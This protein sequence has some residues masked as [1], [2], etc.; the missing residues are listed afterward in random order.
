MNKRDD[1]QRELLDDFM[2]QTDVVLPEKG[3]ITVESR[4]RNS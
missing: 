2:K 3:E 1:F 4:S